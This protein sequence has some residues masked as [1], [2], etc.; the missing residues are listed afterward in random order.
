[1]EVS[2]DGESRIASPLTRPTSF[3]HLL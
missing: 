2:K 3:P 1:M